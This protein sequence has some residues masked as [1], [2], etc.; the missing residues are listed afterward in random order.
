MAALVFVAGLGPV[1]GDAGGAPA[2]DLSRVR[3]LAVAPFLDE[4]PLTRPLTAAAAARLALLLR[5]APFQVI[6]PSMAAAAMAEERMGLRD[7]VS[8]SRSIALAQ[9]LGADAVLTGRVIEVDQGRSGRPGHGAMGFEAKAR[10][11]F[12]V[13]DAGTRLK[14]LEE[15][16]ACAGRPLAADAL[17]CVVQALAARLLGS[18]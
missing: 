12:R 5:R 11:D 15:E 16:I 18:R 17:E 7:L 6:G 9:R 4:D 14:L 2:P 3:V 1:A 10:I 13:L 8:P